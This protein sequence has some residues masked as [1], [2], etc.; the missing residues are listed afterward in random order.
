LIGEGAICAVYIFLGDSL[1]RVL[2]W[3]P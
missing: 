1:L 3:Q 2:P